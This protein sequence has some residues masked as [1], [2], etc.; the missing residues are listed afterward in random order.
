M[1]RQTTAFKTNYQTRTQANWFMRFLTHTFYKQ[2]HTQNKNLNNQKMPWVQVIWKL[3]F[4]YAFCSGCNGIRWHLNRDIYTSAAYTI[5]STSINNTTSR[6]KWFLVT[7]STKRKLLW[8]KLLHSV[9]PSISP[10]EWRYTH[11]NCVSSFVCV[12]LDSKPK[13]YCFSVIFFVL[14]LAWN[15]SALLVKQY[16]ESWNYRK[17]L[18]VYVWDFHSFVSVME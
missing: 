3:G 13:L 4:L 7:D 12:T 15:A 16:K 14:S 6:A 17:P 1:H 5:A 2:N 18:T 9:R 8:T 10:C 11:V